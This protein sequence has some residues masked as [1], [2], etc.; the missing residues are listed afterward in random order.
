[1]HV[2]RRSE[3]SGIGLL[4]IPLGVDHITTGNLFFLFLRNL[5]YYREPLEKAFSPLVPYCI[6]RA[7]DCLLVDDNFLSP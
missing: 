6:D 5:V 4:A 7:S 3:D 1:M 2:D